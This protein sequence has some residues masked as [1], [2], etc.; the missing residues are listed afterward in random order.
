MADR[1]HAL[2]L[3]HITQQCLPY[4]AF[5][6][7]TNYIPL[8]PNTPSWV[9][10]TL[11]LF[12]HWKYQIWLKWRLVKSV[13]NSLASTQRMSSLEPQGKILTCR[14]HPWATDPGQHASPST[15]GYCLSLLEIKELKLHTT[16]FSPTSQWRLQT[17]NSCVY[18]KLLM[19][20]V[21]FRRVLFS[22]FFF[23]N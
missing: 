17:T 7:L 9:L 23:S 1:C 20:Y 15:F 14:T 4:R 10:L 11:S 16:Y 22:F 8:K 3:W 13:T 2:L 19:L 21:F 6:I 12:S 5:Q 18:L